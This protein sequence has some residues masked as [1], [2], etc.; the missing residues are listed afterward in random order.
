[1]ISN[2]PPLMKYEE[3]FL[4][5]EEEMET[6]EV[7]AQISKGT[8]KFAS[9]LEEEI[10][11]STTTLD[12]ELKKDVSDLDMELE[13]GSS[14]E[15][16][17]EVIEEIIDSIY[18]PREII[19]NGKRFLL[20]LSR[21]PS[22]RSD[23]E[24]LGKVF[25][26]YVKERQV[27]MHGYCPIRRELYDLLFN[28]L[29]RQAT[30]FCPERGAMLLRIRDEL[31]LT[32]ATYEKL[33]ESSVEYGSQKSL[34]AITKTRCADIQCNQLKDEI[35]QAEKKLKTIQSKIKTKEILKKQQLERNQL[36]HQ[37]HMEFLRNA[38]KQLKEQL[39]YL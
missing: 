15:L 26:E 29:I 27:R 5:D 2:E 17:D 22:S 14:V 8:F 10:R 11:K 39:S 20:R 30:L 32:I 1:M 34:D 31:L 21:E 13:P 19:R 6:E 35:R 18:I 9:S 12:E 4:P 24:H 16:H 7:E 36:H 38:N 23:I 33:F 28:E 37:E 25:D 3:V